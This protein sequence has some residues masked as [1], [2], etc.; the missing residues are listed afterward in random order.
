MGTE[1]RS[2]RMSRTGVTKPM[3]SRIPRKP[4]AAMAAAAALLAAAA[5]ASPASA[6][7]FKEYL[8]AKPDGTPVAAGPWSNLTHGNIS[9]G[10]FGASMGE[11]SAPWSTTA[12]LAAPPNMTIASA[13]ADRHL[14]APV[15]GAVHQPRITTTW[16]TRG[17]TGGGYAGDSGSGPVSINNPASLS[18]TVSCESGMGGSDPAP[19][20]TGGGYWYADR[21]ELT[22]RDDDAPSAALANGG[23]EIL[24]GEWKTSPN[25]EF[26][27]TASD[28]GGGVYRAFVRDATTTYYTSIDASNARCQDARPGVGDAYEFVAS[29]T[30]LVPCR[31]ANQ[32]YTPTFDLSPLGD[33]SHTGLSFGVEDAAGNEAIIASNRTVRLNLP[34]GDLPDP[35]TLGPGG[36]VYEVDGTTCTM[37][38]A[39]TAKP[40]VSGTAEEGQTLTTTRGTW[41]GTSAATTYAYLWERC[42]AGGPL[43]ACTPIA[44]ATGASYTLKAGDVGK[45]IRSVVT[46][47][48]KGASVTATSDPS[49]TVA[50]KP[51]GGGGGGG[52]AGGG[53]SNVGG[54]GG[55]G[56]STKP[57]ADESPAGPVAPPVDIPTIQPQPVNG[58]NGSDRPELCTGQARG[59]VC[60]AT[61]NKK[62][63]G[64]VTINVPYGQRVPISGRVVDPA[65][66]P[67]VGA[68]IDIR[69]IDNVPGAKAAAIKTVRTDS[70]GV[71]RFVAPV[72]VSRTITFG[73]R[74]REGDQ[75]YAGTSTL[76]IAVNAKINV[77]PS[78]RS[79]RN[80]Q[81]VIFRGKVAGAPMNSNKRVEL[82]AKVGS[83]WRTIG[84][85]KLRKGKY[86]IA[87][88]FKRTTVTSTYQFRARVMPAMAWPFEA[89]YSKVVSVKVR[90]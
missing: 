46:A 60:D 49:G 11:V 74:Y 28:S 6:G 67:I 37:P 53:S 65:G 8:G 23:G 59:K 5:G 56:G 80:K 48:E 81:K 34:G 36:C 82:Q 20:C 33:G 18:I 14:S 12:T 17:W 42:P 47:T 88:H 86:A 66:R 50:A 84:N 62:I 45:Q 89:G 32:A 16:E 76:V 52:G 27:L 51:A 2:Q 78:K 41:T 55:G 54:G 4:V 90:P 63:N 44:D 29:T 39:A 57:P 40:Q 9:G 70:N 58:Q 71:Y 83:V 15:S 3:S 79:A 30:S 10:P 13:W 72:G 21:M 77:K 24:D 25:V 73:Y 85:A 7:T 64:V 1:S 31:T 35:G 69:S 61:R 19:R 22:L 38:L 87:Y 43:T 26:E 68:A 75:E